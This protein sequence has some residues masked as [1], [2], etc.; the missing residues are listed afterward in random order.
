M[1]KASWQGVW[2]RWGLLASA[3]VL[4]AALIL[5]SWANYRSAQAARTA[6]HYGQTRIF[7]G[8]F[9]GLL[10]DSFEPGD[11][12]GMKGIVDSLL[13][14]QA[15]NGLLHVSMLDEEGKVTA[16]AGER[17]PEPLVD[18]RGETQGVGGYGIV[19]I[20]SR[21]RAFL[22]RPHRPPGES[23]R[24]KRT[25]HPGRTERSGDEEPG[26]GPPRPPRPGGMVI[27]FEPVIA[28][29]LVN[30]AKRVLFFGLAAAV[31]MMIVAVVSWI[32]SV[33]YER[34]TERLEHERRL[35][36]LGQMS[37][38]LAHE[39]RNPLA[40]LKGNAQ[41]LAERLPSDSPD[42]GKAD[43]VV[44]EASRLEALTSDLLDFAR[45]GPLDHGPVDPSDLVRQSG[46]EIDPD[47]F[48]Y[49]FA[50]APHV[51]DLDALRMRQ[52]LTNLMHNARQA[53]SPEGPR[54]SVA[55]RAEGESLVVTIRDHGAGLPGGQ[56]DRIFDPFF[57]TRA[58]GTGLGLSVARRIVEM[59]GGDVTA[60][61][62]PDGGAVFR[63]EIPR[64][65]D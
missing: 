49:D 30:Q 52:A 63:I 11:P 48:D 25:P 47:G 64:G 18:P 54:P 8:A 53:S 7:E 16:L 12:D 59:H 23:D 6:L 39:I 4:G 9:W 15:G 31:V 65:R 40:S 42:R 55:V 46:G 2:A 58:S 1:K 38:V 33:R 36:L 5:A 10:R 14:Q 56:E 44:L 27:E 13:A 3:V 24:E 57:T 43:R 22:L 41:L 32:G 35:S 62:H 29:D 51:W 61:N 20:G 19:E 26:D 37:A 45:S 34:A 17:D 50:G 28:G 21:V 60:R